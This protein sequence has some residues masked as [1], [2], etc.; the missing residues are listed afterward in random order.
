M[1]TTLAP[2]AILILAAAAAVW[3]AIENRRTRRDVAGMAAA[4][5]DLAAAVGHTLPSPQR[6][7]GPGEEK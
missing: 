6:N 4:V 2:W 5:A 3:A 7:G 1:L